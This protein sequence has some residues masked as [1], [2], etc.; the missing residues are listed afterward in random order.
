MTPAFDIISLFSIFVMITAGILMPVLTPTIA[1]IAAGR[2]IPDSSALAGFFIG[3]PNGLAALPLWIGS[4]LIVF[5]RLHIQDVPLLT[6]T[7][8]ATMARSAAAIA[9]LWQIRKRDAVSPEHSYQIP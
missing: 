1:A 4:K 7:T 2:M 9:I 5:S 8:G 6:Y 3:L